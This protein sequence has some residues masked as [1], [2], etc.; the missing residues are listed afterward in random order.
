[1]LEITTNNHSRPLIYG[2][3]L[4]DEEKQDFDYLDNIEEDFTGFRYKNQ[5]YSLDQFMRIENH[6]SIDFNSW[7]GYHSDSFFSGI[8][9]KF[10]DCGESVIVGM[11]FS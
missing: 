9:V 2:H 4:T 8:L 5:V 3:E 10:S 6:T 1:M 11:Y 7:D